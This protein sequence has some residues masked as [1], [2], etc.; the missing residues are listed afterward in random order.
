MTPHHSYPLPRT[1]YEML[2]TLS[3]IA[4]VLLTVVATAFSV[5]GVLGVFR[6]PDVYQRLHAAGMVATFGVVLLLAA[7]VLAIGV[8][9][10]K[11]VVLIALILIAGPVASHAIG[12]AAYRTG[13]PLRGS[14]R[15][16]LAKKSGTEGR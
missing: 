2:T 6:F 10:P 4:V 3:D 5:I 8:S 11:A 12:S 1:G 9:V 7:A 15:D 14:G 13:V 16:D